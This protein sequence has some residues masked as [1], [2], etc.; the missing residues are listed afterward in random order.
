MRLNAVQTHFYVSCVVL[1]HDNHGGQLGNRVVTSGARAMKRA[2]PLQ[3][4][5]I[6]LSCQL[7]VQEQ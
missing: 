1:A 5:R 7:H 6:A 2:A 4:L 3:L